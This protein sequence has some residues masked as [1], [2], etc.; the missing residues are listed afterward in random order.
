MGRSRSCAIA[1]RLLEVRF[2]MADDVI[3]KG[4]LNALGATL[5]FAVVVATLEWSYR[6]ARRSKTI[7]RATST[8]KRAST[9]DT[10]DSAKAFHYLYL[11]V[12]RGSREF[13]HYSLAVRGE[14]A[15]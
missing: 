13:I 5:A 2:G 1:V 9:A 15:L 6:R 14:R 3:V 8:R 10:R 11:P 12:H 4:L 7:R